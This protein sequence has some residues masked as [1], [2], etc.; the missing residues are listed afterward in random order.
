MCE[1]YFLSAAALAHAVTTHGGS[2]DTL[3]KARIPDFG[4][5]R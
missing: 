2:G 5:D 1:Q 4:L 3:E